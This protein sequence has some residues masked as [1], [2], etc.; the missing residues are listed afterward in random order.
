[1]LYDFHKWQNDKRPGSLHATYII[2][3]TKTKPKVDD[4][5]VEMTDSQMSDDRHAP[6]SDLVPTHTLSLV[7][8]EQLHGQSGRSNSMLAEMI[9]NACFRVV[10]GI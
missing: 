2:Y 5:D 10:D 4:E 3:G 6:F 9:T 7:S 8:E 1:M